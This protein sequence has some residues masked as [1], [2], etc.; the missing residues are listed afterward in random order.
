VSERAEV[1][2]DDGEPIDGVYAAGAMVGGLFYGRYP[3]G[4][5]LMAGATFGRIAGLEA[6]ARARS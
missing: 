2:A 4:A 5:G 6:A 3:S 1:L